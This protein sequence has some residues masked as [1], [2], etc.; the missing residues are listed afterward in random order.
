MLLGGY[1]DAPYTYPYMSAADA[2]A[3]Q[4]IAGRYELLEEIARGGMGTVWVAQDDKLGRKV[5]IKVMRAQSLEAFPD[6]R[7]RF[8]REAKAAAALRSSHVVQVHDYGVEDGTPFIAMELLE[9]HSLKQRLR[10]V[11][12]FDVSEAANTLK[13][14]AK[15]LKAAHRK[16][17]VHRDLK[18][19]NIFLALRDDSEIVKLLDFGVVKSLHRQKD[20]TASGVMLGTPQYMSP[21]QARG[22]KEIDHRADLWSLGVILYTLLAGE[23][24]FESDADAIGDIVIRVCFNQVPK[25]S[26]L[27]DDLP[28]G[29]DAFFDK[30]LAKRRILRFQSIEE[31]TDAFMVAADVTYTGLEGELSNPSFRG[32]SSS[33]DWESPLSPDS[34][35]SPREAPTIPTH[36]PASDSTLGGSLVDDSHSTQTSRRRLGTVL[37][38]AAIGISVGFGVRALVTPTA[39]SAKPASSSET[40]GD[41]S[42]D[43]SASTAATDAPPKDSAEPVSSEEPG[44]DAA[45]SSK[46]AAR[47]PATITPGPP[48]PGKVPTP[49]TK[50]TAKPSASAPQPVDTG[51]PTGDEPP[52]WYRKKK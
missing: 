19:S 24:P 23:N 27:H 28:S 26:L 20:D 6:A 22:M 14:I 3:G 15:G 33:G 42:A 4:V 9:G 45:P 13:Q 21:E 7:E 12:R 52:Q 17:L 34:Y 5:A 8:E 11:G 18:P 43:A 46:T 50:P 10:D 35:S 36:R 1:R 25:I 51:T 38:V 29:L 2:T 31:M 37:A 48:E 40:V 44:A 39:E 32:G 41:A 30:A 16:G 47:P 49:D